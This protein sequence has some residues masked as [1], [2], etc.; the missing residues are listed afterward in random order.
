MCSSDLVLSMASRL[1]APVAVDPGA[2]DMVAQLS[3]QIASISV[4]AALLGLSIAM[5]VT[6]VLCG[7]CR[8]NSRRWR[9]ATCAAR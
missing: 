4:I 8:S 5:G 9:R 6:R 2:S 3:L 7:R 1:F